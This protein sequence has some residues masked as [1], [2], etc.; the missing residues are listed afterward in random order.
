MLGKI[1]GQGEYHDTILSDGITQPEVTLGL[2]ELL[3]VG[4]YLTGRPGVCLHH[5]GFQRV[6]HN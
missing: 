1:G 5:E 4:R 6:G 3:G 2:V